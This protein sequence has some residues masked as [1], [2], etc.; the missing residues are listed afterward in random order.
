MDVEYYP[1]E[2]TGCYRALKPVSS[3]IKGELGEDVALLVAAY[4]RIMVEEEMSRSF[5]NM[6]T[7]EG[8]RLAGLMKDK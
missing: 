8:L 4:H 3:W 6:I 2:L 1:K 7:E 5:P